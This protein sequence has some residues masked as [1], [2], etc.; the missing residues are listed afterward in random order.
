MSEKRNEFKR[1]SA[2]YSSICYGQSAGVKIKWKSAIHSL[3]YYTIASRS[4]QKEQINWR[5]FGIAMLVS[6]TMRTTGMVLFVCHFLSRVSLVQ[7]QDTFNFEIAARVIDKISAFTYIIERALDIPVKLAL[8]GSFPLN[9]ASITAPAILFPA[10]NGIPDFV[11]SCSLCQANGHFYGYP[12]EP[13][14]PRGFGFVETF[15]PL[16]T[17]ASTY[18][19]NNDGTRGQLQKLS[20]YECGTRGWYKESKSLGYSTWSSPNLSPVTGQ[21]GLFLQY[22]IFNTTYIDSSGEI[23]ISAGSKKFIATILVVT[24]LSNIVTFLSEA[25]KNSDRKVFLVDKP[26]GILLA[27]SFDA[28]L[29]SKSVAGKTVRSLK[30]LSL[31]KDNVS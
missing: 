14:Y 22:P 19:V 10:R 8:S 17:N 21:F 20:T 27:S 9:N 30:K 16:Y 11:G 28:V 7:A 1:S 3:F 4:A 12:A 5:Y 15:P 29:T 31:I 25:Y 18:L 24:Y 13:T 23:K 2:I 26:T 6:S